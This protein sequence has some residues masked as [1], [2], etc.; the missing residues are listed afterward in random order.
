[1]DTKSISIVG[2]ILF[3]LAEQVEAECRRVTLDLF[4]RD[5]EARLLDVGCP[6]CSQ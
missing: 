4:V 6:A 5:A 2:R 3:K 1:M